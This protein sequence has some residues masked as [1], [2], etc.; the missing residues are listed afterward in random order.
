MSVSKQ[1]AGH[2]V[3]IGV[4]G[5]VVIIIIVILGIVFASQYGRV[6]SGKDRITSQTATTKERNGQIE[7]DKVR[8]EQA[9]TLADRL[10]TKVLV[11]KEQIASNQAGLDSLTKSNDGS[12][13]TDPSTGKPYVFVSD[14]H[15]M[16]VGEATFRTSASCD[17]KVSGSGG[18]GMIID[19][20]ASS[21]AVA[22]KLESGDYAC[23]TNL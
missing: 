23:E 19:A 14:Q 22:I 3:A 16:Q 2:S 7:R 12:F 11:A 8:Y 4:I 13:V 15:K 20:S 5:V 10:F 1:Q 18:K 9:M 21:V 6:Q 17:D